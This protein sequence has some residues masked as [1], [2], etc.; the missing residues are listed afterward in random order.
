MLMLCVSLLA[1][2][3]T[4]AYVWVQKRYKFWQE[5]GFVQAN[6]TFPFGN[7]KGVGHK[8]HMSSIITK[9]Y[10]K[11][12]NSAPMVGMYFF[13]APLILVMDLEIIKHIMVKDFSFFHDRGMYFNVKDDPISGHLFSIEGKEWKDMRAKLTPTFTSGKMKMMFDTVLK[14]SK[15]MTEYLNIPGRPKEFEMKELLCQFTTDVIGN[16]AFGLEMNC[17]KDPNSMFRT[18]G[19]KIFA[20][21]P[22]R[23]MKIFFMMQ[24]RSFARSLGMR[25]TDKDVSDFFMNSIAETVDFREKNNVVRPDFMNLLLQIK[26]KGNINESGE[27]EGTIT[28]NEMAAQCFLFFIAGQVLIIALTTQ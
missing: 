24:F 8:E 18:M 17:I 6:P 11:H 28:L 23:T 10:K 20:T 14:I 21:P 4:L 15:E 22:F 16:I 3:V 2:V 5:R 13:T 7:I 27:N 25:F 19:R 12:K 1:I 9:L 26:N